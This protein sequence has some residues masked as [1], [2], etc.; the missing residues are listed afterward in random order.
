V[1]KISERQKYPYLVQ[2]YVDGARAKKLKM[3]S[4]KTGI[5]KSTLIRRGIDF[6]IEL[7]YKQLGIPADKKVN[8]K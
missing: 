1:K 6:V 8:G 5:P 3:L 2:A 7:T 4:E